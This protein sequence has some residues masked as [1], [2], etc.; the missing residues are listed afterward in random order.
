LRLELAGEVSVDDLVVLRGKV[1]AALASSTPRV[2]YVFYVPELSAFPP[3]GLR[4]ILD[5][6]GLLRSA[7]T[8]RLAVIGASDGARLVLESAAL[9]L[10]LSIGYFED[11]RE[12]LAF[13]AE[14][15]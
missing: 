9:A 8:G 3:E 7:K 2:D 1:K 12:A 6:R 13:I 5:K 15:G 11:E 14:R 4:M 10:R